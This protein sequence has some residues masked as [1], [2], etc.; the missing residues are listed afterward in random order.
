MCKGRQGPQPQQGSSCCRALAKAVAV[1]CPT[2]ST[3]TIPAV[4]LSPLSY[5]GEGG[6]E[7][8]SSRSHPT[9][10]ATPHTPVRSRCSVLAP[11][12]LPSRHCRQN[13]TVLPSTAAPRQ[14]SSHP[15]PHKPW[16]LPS[17]CVNS[18]FAKASQYVT[19]PV[20]LKSQVSLSVF[21][22]LS[23]W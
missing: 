21:L 9:F 4:R 5:V 17:P 18:E 2:W 14:P 6:R 15:Q 12:T 23:V 11:S 1:L 8:H 7:Q 3:G 16:P 19:Q 22:M 20:S 10:L 13:T